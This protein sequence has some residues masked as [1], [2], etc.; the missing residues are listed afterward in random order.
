MQ[1][2]FL[3]ERV[4]YNNEVTQ[5]FLQKYLQA[6][7]RIEGWFSY[8]AALMFM[9]YNQLLASRG[10]AANVLEIGAHHGLSSIA[11]ATLR[12]PGA[13]FYVV[14]ASTLSTSWNLFTTFMPE[15]ASHLPLLK[16]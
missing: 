14:F 8:D 11:V 9:A 4:A 12:A 15:Y 13:N 3:G 2:R 16:F 10:I 5:S 7:Q 6:F 1:E